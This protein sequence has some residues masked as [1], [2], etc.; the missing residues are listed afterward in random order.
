MGDNLCFKGDVYYF[1]EYFRA[2]EKRNLTHKLLPK[3][4]ARNLKNTLEELSKK[5]YD[6]GFSEYAILDED[7]DD[8]LRFQLKEKEVSLSGL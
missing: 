4:A 7:I 5:C 8:M 2:E 6:D 1:Y 3:R